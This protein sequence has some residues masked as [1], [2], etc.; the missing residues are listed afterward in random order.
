M[1]RQEGV[2]AGPASTWI[3][4]G[5]F[6]VA[7]GVHR[8]P[9]PLPTDGLKAVNTY[10]IESSS[11]HTLVDPGWAIAES[12]ARLEAGLGRL[13]VAL[14]DIR[15]FLVTHIHRDH[16]TQAVALRRE[17]GAR[18][19]LGAGE[20]PSLRFLAEP[21]NRP[22]EGSIA[23][24]RRYGAD[25]L[26]DAVEQGGVGKLEG[27]EY[28]P[29]DSWLTSSSEID[30]GDRTLRVIATPGHTR[31]H[32]VFH[33]PEANL[34]FSGDH[35]LPHI[36]PSV[37]FEPVASELPLRDYL[38][39]LRILQS[40]PDTRLLP[41]HGPPVGSTHTRVEEL[42]E[43]H[44]IR[45]TATLDAITNGGTTAF[46]VAGLLTWTRHSRTFESL[47]RFNQMLAVLETGRHLDLLA[48]HGRLNVQHRDG[49]R[50]FV[51]T[52]EHL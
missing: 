2:D 1:T 32:V 15:L 4:E 28:E 52:Q 6:E 44:E 10:L 14:A 45:L 13:G 7:D 30:L 34:L 24:L 27:G 20:E 21:G 5:A 22:L 49:I 43:H 35:V 50:V 51:L 37:G 39:S 3:D 17:F 33:E 47:D 46:E 48:I 16:F 9:L 40:I 36:T 19:A 26:A 42:L 29:P 11:G 25:A 38:D 18:V 41:A 31:G 8:I 23:E 12:R